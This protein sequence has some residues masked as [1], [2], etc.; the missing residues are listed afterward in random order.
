MGK[1]Y[2]LATNNT[3]LDHIKKKCFCSNFVKIIIINTV[4]NVHNIN[5]VNNVKI[6]N[7]IFERV[8]DHEAKESEWKDDQGKLE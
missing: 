2:E 3:N 6:L 5:T 8:E 1:K 7:R 4:Y